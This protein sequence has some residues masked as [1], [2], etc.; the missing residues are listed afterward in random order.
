MK[1]AHVSIEGRGETDRFLS[2][3]ADRIGQSGLRLAGAV[4]TNIHRAD[5]LKCDM[6][7]RV[8]PDGPTVRI[9]EDRGMFARGCMLDHAAL[10]QTVVEVWRRLGGADVLIVN[11]FGKAES[12]GRGLAPV[13]AEALARGMRVLVGVNRLNLSDYLAFAGGLSEPLPPVEGAVA[14]W[15]GQAVASPAA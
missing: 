5:R 13:I 3:V 10:E 9:S 12:L 11:K 4:Q 7:L 1:L 8:L 15:C 2:A 14:L 6:D